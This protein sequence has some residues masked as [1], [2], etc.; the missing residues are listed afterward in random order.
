MRKVSIAEIVHAKDPVQFA[1]LV[2]HLLDAGVV[3]RRSVIR[4]RGRHPRRAAS[5]GRVPALVASATLLSPGEK[6][7][8]APP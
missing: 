3:R 2:A 1:E 5:C 4:R 6:P 7:I 8:S